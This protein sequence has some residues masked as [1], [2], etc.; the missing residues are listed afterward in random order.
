MN[1]VKHI[2]ALLVVLLCVIGAIR[3]V[4]M[5][6]AALKKA[7]TPLK[8]PVPVKTARIHKGSLALREHYLG[9]IVPLEKATISTRLTG[10][11]LKVTKYEGDPVKKGTLLVEIEARAL[12]A[13]LAGLKAA[14]KG[15]QSELLTKEAIFQRNKKLLAHEA[16]SK[17]AFELSKSALDVAQAK[18]IELRQEIAATKV[19]L[20]YARIYAPFDGVITKRFKDPGDLATP[21]APILTLEN[22]RAGYRVLVKVPQERAHFFI[23]GR[24]AYLLWGPQERPARIYRVHPAVG[25]EALATVELRL[26]QRPF[27]L[28]SGASIGVDLVSGVPQGFILPLKALVRGQNTAVYVVRQG[29]L[30]LVPVKVLGQSKDQIVVSGAL[31]EGETVVIGDPG[32]L[33]R[34]H[35]GQKV[36]ARGS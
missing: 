16:I 36:Q 23:P 9:T 19:D 27:G 31:R 28:P 6:K 17:E 13:K 25:T 35:P 29:R 1:R 24:P 33:L 3:L 15:A 18:V 14:L 8:A 20:S 11:I 26:K 12:E 7:P 4:K 21:G 30:V 34:L 5:K 22:P 32:L 10:Y 2:L